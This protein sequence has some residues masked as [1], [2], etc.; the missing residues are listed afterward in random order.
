MFTAGEIDKVMKQGSY[1][2]DSVITI[3]DIREIVAAAQ[4]CGVLDS[5]INVWKLHDEPEFLITF[6]MDDGFRLC[7]LST[8]GRD[9][10]GEPS[11][12]NA[13]RD[14]VHNILVFAVNSAREL[15]ESHRRR[16]CN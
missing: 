9:I 6:D 2:E 4:D 7:S 10:L 3:F 11:R 13:A 14:S 15:V 16:C 1:D 8:E 5:A 12:L